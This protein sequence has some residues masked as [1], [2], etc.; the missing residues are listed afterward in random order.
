M[1]V[2]IPILSPT[3]NGVCGRP[4]H[5]PVSDFFLALSDPMKL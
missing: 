4:P 5:T 2:S 1:F 3:G